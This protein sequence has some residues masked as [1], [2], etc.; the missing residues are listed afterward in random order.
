ML[1]ITHSKCI[2]C[3]LLYEMQK[4]VF[5]RIFFLFQHKR[6]FAS[7]NFH[8]QEKEKSAFRISAKGGRWQRTCRQMLRLVDNA[9]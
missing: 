5:L 4:A 3:L 8:R 7:P 2:E 1:F 6:L 9:V